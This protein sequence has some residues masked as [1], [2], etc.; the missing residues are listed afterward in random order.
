M[1]KVAVSLH[2]TEDFDPNIIKELNGLDYIHVDVMDGKFVEN[3]QLNLDVFKLIKENYNLPIIAHLMVKNPI[4]YIEK[5]IEFCDIFLFHFES[6]GDIETIIKKVKN[7]NK[8]VG[9]A[10]NPETALPKIIPYLNKIDL[11][12]IMSVN[13]GFSGQE[14]I[15]E[16][17]DKINLLFAYRHQ[18]KLTFDIDVDGG[19]NPENAKL[20]NADILT[21][22]SAILKAEDPNLIIQLLKVSEDFD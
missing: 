10:I 4:N 22:A 16:T 6:N 13:P 15:W 5:V 14:F 11:V 12:L 9:I 3:K 21:S 7:Y 18:N 17:P 20:I 8:K 1:K 19:V 2:A